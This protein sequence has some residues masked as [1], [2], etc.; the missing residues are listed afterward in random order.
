MKPDQY[1][2][3]GNPI[4][5]SKSP[6]LHGDFATTTGE[7]I[8]YRHMLVPLG[9]FAKTARAFFDQGGSGANVTVPF[10]LDA[11]AFADHASEAAQLA[12]AA[13]TLKKTDKGIYADNTDGVGCLRDIT[14]NWGVTVEKR[15]VLI[16]GAGGAVRGLLPALMAHNPSQIS[17]V[18]RTFEKAQALAGEFSSPTL[19]AIKTTELTEPYDVLINCS[20]AGLSGDTL[21]LPD[22]AFHADTHC[23]DMVYGDDLTPFQRWA[24]DRQLAHR[25]GFGMLVEQAAEAF[26]LWRG[27]RPATAHLLTGAQ[28]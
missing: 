15:K 17:I 14:V 20:A 25:A 21:A 28:P 1:V 11:L 22:T 6:Q 27:V 2:V 23:Y 9:D 8:E 18:N 10:K 4:Q 5:H 13:N 12:G 16:I 24:A 19:N 7:N 3:M 26:Q